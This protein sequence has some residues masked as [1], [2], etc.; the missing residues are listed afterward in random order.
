MINFSY[1]KEQLVMIQASY[2]LVFIEILTKA[3]K[4]IKTIVSVTILLSFFT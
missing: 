3:L 2:N 1:Y 4:G